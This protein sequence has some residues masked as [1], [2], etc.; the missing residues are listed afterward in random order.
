MHRKSLLGLHFF[1]Y[2]WFTVIIEVMER[3]E[4]VNLGDRADDDDYLMNLR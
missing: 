2:Y 4:D 1:P 3:D